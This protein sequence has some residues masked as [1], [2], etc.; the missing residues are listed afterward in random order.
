MNL[1][2]RIQMLPGKLWE[3]QSGSCRAV[4]PAAFGWLVESMLSSISASSRELGPGVC[5]IF[6]THTP[7]F[8]V[9]LIHPLLWG[10]PEWHVPVLC[11][12]SWSVVPDCG[13]KAA[14]PSI[15]SSQHD[16][17]DVGPEWLAQVAQF[18]HR[19]RSRICISCPLVPHSFHWPGKSFPWK[20]APKTWLRNAGA[21]GQLRCD[22][23][24]NTLSPE[25][26]LWGL[27][28]SQLQFCWTLPRTDRLVI[29]C[30]PRMSVHVAGNIEFLLS[31]RPVLYSS[32]LTFG[33][34]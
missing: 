25:V 14:W 28:P 32:A 18:L 1:W 15:S 7:K 12:V 23:I 2:Q 22:K 8:L 10:L 20:V 33:T 11:L 5:S 26:G 9:F 24:L 30:N 19:T 6:T 13:Y 29:F 31:Q 17:T 21:R 34:Q 16:V 27:L 4:W 3:E